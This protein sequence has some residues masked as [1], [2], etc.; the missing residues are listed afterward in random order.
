MDIK[1]SKYGIY[2]WKILKRFKV[3]ATY[4]DYK[5]ELLSP[6]SNKD[7]NK[8]IHQW[9]ELMLILSKFQVYFFKKG[10]W[11]NFRSLKDTKPFGCLL[12]GDTD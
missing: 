6:I 7:T 4:A 5:K 9:Y 10:L 8:D 12:E 11:C 2:K 3:R 1:E